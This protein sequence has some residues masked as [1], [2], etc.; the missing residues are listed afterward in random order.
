L[1]AIDGDG[2]VRI[3]TTIETHPL[4]DYGA[5]D[6]LLLEIIDNGKGISKEEMQ[7]I[8]TLGYTTTPHGSGMGLVITKVLIESF[9]GELNITSQPGIGTTVSV[10]LPI[11]KGINHA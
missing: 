11:I 8:F 5:T 9:G 10:Y 6:V 1:T 4:T 3:H 7:H 2:D